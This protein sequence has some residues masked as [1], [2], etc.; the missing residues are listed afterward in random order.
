MTLR[1][2]IAL[3]LFGV[4][5]F[6]YTLSFALKFNKLS[7][8]FF[9]KRLR[10]FHLIMIWLIP[11]IW[12]IILKAIMRPYNGLKKNDN[13]KDIPNIT[14]EFSWING[15]YNIFHSDLNTHSGSTPDSQSHGWHG[16]DHYGNDGHHGGFS[17]SSGGGAS[18]HQDLLIQ[19]VITP[20]FSLLTIPK[21]AFIFTPSAYPS[22]SLNFHN[23]N[24]A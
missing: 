17:D 16:S 12:I 8:K 7:N 23:S 18:H 1:I 5:Y 19:S 11:F 10:L 4:V 20:S 14:N 2:I 3:S 21:I 6:L 9:S 13:T 22:Y 24:N 15:F